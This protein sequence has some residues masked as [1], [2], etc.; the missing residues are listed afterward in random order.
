MTDELVALSLEE[1]IA[2]LETA[3]QRLIEN[4]GIHQENQKILHGAVSG[5]YPRIVAGQDEAIAA[6]NKNIK[7]LGELFKVL[8]KHVTSLLESRDVDEKAITRIERLLQ[9]KDQVIN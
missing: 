9:G 8:D 2:E 7:G 4:D 3:V 6:L 1:R 5:E